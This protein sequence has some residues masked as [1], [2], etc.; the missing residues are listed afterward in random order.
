[1]WYEGTRDECFVT[2]YDNQISTVAAYFEKQNAT[3]NPD[4]DVEEIKLFCQIA[5]Q[6]APVDT[7]R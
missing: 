4:S 6:I 7:K 1:M 2:S 5:K 3:L